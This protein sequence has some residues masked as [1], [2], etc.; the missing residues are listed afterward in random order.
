MCSF[1]LVKYVDLCG[2]VVRSGGEQ[3]E[4]NFCENKSLSM[5]I[6]RMTSEA[7]VSVAL[8]THT[9]QFFFFQ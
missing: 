9:E 2:L 1:T 5:Q 3:Y 8:P 4:I 6:L 7:K